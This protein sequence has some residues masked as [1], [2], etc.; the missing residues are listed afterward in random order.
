[1]PLISIM[2]NVGCIVGP[3]IGGTF[4]LHTPQ[5]STRTLSLRSCNYSW[6]TREC[7][8]MVGSI[9]LMRSDIR[10]LLPCAMGALIT[11][12]TITLS[13]F[14]L[15]ETLVSK[16]ARSY[17]FCI[18]ESDESNNCTAHVPSDVSTALFSTPSLTLIG[19]PEDRPSDNPKTTESPHLPSVLELLR[20]RPLQQV[21]LSTAILNILGTGGDVV[22]VLI[23][24]TPI[25]LGGLSRTVG[26]R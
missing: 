9:S 5:C 15:E 12:S 20:Y 25:N 11:L 16:V 8:P 18:S 23:C 19:E 10:Y 3:L 7:S 14:C 13:Y 26:F 1:M 4:A 2:S 21:V 17:C 6:I 24:Y 22:F